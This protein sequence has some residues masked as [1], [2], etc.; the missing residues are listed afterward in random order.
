MTSAAELLAQRRGQALLRSAVDLSDRITSEIIQQG[1]RPT[2]LACAL[3][4]AHESERTSSGFEPAIEPVWW[5]LHSR[6][7]AGPNGALLTDA[8]ASLTLVGQC[9]AAHW[10]YDSTLGFGT[11]EPPDAAGSPP[12]TRAGARIFSPAHDGVEE[13]AEDVLAAGH[14][15][16]AIIEVTDEFWKPQD[17]GFVPVP[18]IRATSGGYHAVLLVGVWTDPLHGR[19]FLVRNSW[20]ETWGAGG[21]C[22]L[23]VGYLIANCVQL[24]EVEVDRWP[25]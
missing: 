21:Y 24:T 5:H 23:D 10:P 12:W 19:V 16:V 2:C 20:G 11:E 6:G 1:P 8:L 25:S 3:S 15:I 18:P 4:S 22:L 17:D 13:E 7:L 14:P 9:P